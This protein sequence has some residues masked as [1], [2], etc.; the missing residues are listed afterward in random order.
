VPCPLGQ[1][2]AFSFNPVKPIPRDRLA[3]LTVVFDAVLICFST[4]AIQGV[5]AVG[6]WRG[7]RWAEYLTF[8]ATAL[9]VPLEAYQ[10]GHR[11]TVL[12]GITLVI[13]VA[14]VVYL[15]IAKR[16]CGL[17]GGEPGYG[18][19]CSTGA[20]GRCGRDRGYHRRPS[21]GDAAARYRG[22]QGG[23]FGS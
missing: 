22:T 18:P 8:V 6:L 2:S 13:D 14:I 17:R 23:P 21:S 15:V 5:E 7:R 3:W 20:P 10:I 11:P 12:R 1:R 9:R 16:Q 19:G 4:S